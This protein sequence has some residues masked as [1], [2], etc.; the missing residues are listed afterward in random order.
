MEEATD[1]SG[2]YE[3]NICAA[4]LNFLSNEMILN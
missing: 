2:Y 3:K 1:V 4:A